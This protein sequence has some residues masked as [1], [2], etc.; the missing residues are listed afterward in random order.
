MKTRED[1]SSDSLVDYY[2]VREKKD[3]CTDPSVLDPLDSDQKNSVETDIATMLDEMDRN[4][5]PEKGG[6]YLRDIVKR[7]K[8]V[9]R[10]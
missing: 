1:L 7:H 9:F 2:R 4:E 5:K 8:H 6:K 10:T 3:P